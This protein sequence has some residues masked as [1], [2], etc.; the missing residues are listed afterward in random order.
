MPRSKSEAAKL[1]LSKNK[2]KRTAIM[3]MRALERW[4]KTSKEDRIKHAKKMVSAR[5]AKRLA[6]SEQTAL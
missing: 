3:R 4:A 5:E 6:G 2:K 1:R